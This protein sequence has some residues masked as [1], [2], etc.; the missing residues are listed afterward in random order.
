[1]LDN[2]ANYDT[3]TTDRHFEFYYIYTYYTILYLTVFMHRRKR[4]F[5]QFINFYYLI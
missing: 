5:E 4:F 2:I 3:I 1:M